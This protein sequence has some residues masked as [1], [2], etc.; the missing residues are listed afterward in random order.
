MKESVATGKRIAL[1]NDYIQTIIGLAIF[2]SLA[3]I[4][5]GKRIFIIPEF[6]FICST[7][8]LKISVYTIVAT[9]VL[10]QIISSITLRKHNDKI[11]KNLSSFLPLTFNEK[12]TFAIVCLFAGICEELIF[13]GFALTF[14]QQFET[15]IWFAVPISA[16]AFGL[17]H[18]YQGISGLF[19]SFFMGILL[20]IV[21]AISGN[22]L[23]PVIIHIITDIC[24]VI[25]KKE[26]KIAESIKDNCE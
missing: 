14:M 16:A 22:L 18:L 11:P 3:V 9:I 20:A 19:T 7:G 21:F 26:D 25:V 8:I 17:M 23:L 4:A 10:Y 24:V 6:Y 1:T 5:C 12:L 2:G 15:G 13:R